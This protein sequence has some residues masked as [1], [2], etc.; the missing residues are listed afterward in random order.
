ML[1]KC[2]SPK[3]HRLTV[4]YNYFTHL[5]SESLVKGG[6]LI[7]PCLNDSLLAR[8]ETWL[9]DHISRGLPTL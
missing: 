6:T 4:T 8:K 3:Y 2:L 5:L 1:Q 7:I 9:K